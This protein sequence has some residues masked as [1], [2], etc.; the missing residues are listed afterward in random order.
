MRMYSTQTYDI[1]VGSSMLE[2]GILTILPKINYLFIVTLILENMQLDAYM[3]V[4]DVLALPYFHF[5]FISKLTI[6]TV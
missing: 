6:R 4:L 2:L 1:G 3:S 5:M